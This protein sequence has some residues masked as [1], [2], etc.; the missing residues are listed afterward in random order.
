MMLCFL[1]YRVNVGKGAPKIKQCTTRLH[2][3]QLTIFCVSWVPLSYIPCS[4]Y[5]CWCDEWPVP[6]ST[7]SSTTIYH[8][9]TNKQC[10]NFFFACFFFRYKNLYCYDF[11]HILITKIVTNTIKSYWLAGM[12]TP[13]SPTSTWNFQP[14]PPP[15]QKKKKKK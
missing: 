1:S 2:R 6:S 9:Y 11:P 8:P 7:L 15:P 14:P 13:L 4:C 12:L 3:V 10:E 5:V